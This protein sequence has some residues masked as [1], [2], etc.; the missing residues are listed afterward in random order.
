MS[1]RPPVDD[2][3]RAV[4]LRLLDQDSRRGADRLERVNRAGIR[5]LATGEAR[6]AYAVGLVVGIVIVVLPVSW[7][8]KAPVIAVL[9]VSLF[10]L[11]PHWQARARFAE[12]RQH[13]ERS[14]RCPACWYSL[15]GVASVDD[16]CVICPECGAAWRV[17]LGDSE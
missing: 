5:H 14:A 13:A 11:Y 2:R 8:V 16:G 17:V 7:M 1:R 4:E 3:G 9:I 12:R 6:V 15:A 10:R